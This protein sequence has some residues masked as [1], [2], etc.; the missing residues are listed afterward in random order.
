M[1]RI[2]R[3]YAP[4][5]A[6]AATVLVAVAWGFPNYFSAM[7]SWWI[8]IGALLATQL[9]VEY[10]KTRSWPRLFVAGIVVGLCFTVKQTGIYVLIGLMLILAFEEQSRQPLRSGGRSCWNSLLLRVAGLLVF[11]GGLLWLVRP[12]SSVAAFLVLVVPMLAIALFVVCDEFRRDEATGFS[13]V[14]D[15]AWAVA[16]ALGGTLLPVAL[17]LTPYLMT[18]TV[19][20]SATEYSWRRRPVMCSAGSTYLH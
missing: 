11:C 5:P 3:E 15:L 14:A 12:W 4:E 19:G 7:P 20:A 18:H 8:L 17:M 9:T 13:R 16:I 10:V 6:A 2:A 1:F